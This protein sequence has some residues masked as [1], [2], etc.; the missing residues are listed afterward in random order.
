MPYF[1]TGLE[2]LSP[3]RGW[4]SGKL[5]TSEEI[6][7]VLDWFLTEDKELN[8]LLFWRK[9]E[10]ELQ[11]WILQYVGGQISLLSDKEI[12]Q[13]WKNYLDYLKA[14]NGKTLET[15]THKQVY[16]HAR[17]TF[18]KMY[19]SRTE[20]RYFSNWRVGIVVDPKQR[21]GYMSGSLETVFSDEWNKKT[22]NTKGED[23]KYNGEKPMTNKERFEEYQ[24]KYIAKQKPSPKPA[25]SRPASSSCN[26]C[27][28]P[29]KP[30]A[31]FCGQCGTP[32][33]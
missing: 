24:E 12:N 15:M 17:K 27:G 7:Q 6:Q 19:Y 9:M 4:A 14:R 3:P 21:T 10:T 31:K 16:T 32:R 2:H 30:E 11:N 26:S 18:E 33:S 8:L 28:K 22:H 5:L 23:M 13:L 25:E 1:E 20:Q 29:L